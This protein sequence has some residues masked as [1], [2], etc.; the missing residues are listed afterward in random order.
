MSTPPTTITFATDPSTRVGTVTLSPPDERKPPT[1]DHATLAALDAAITEAEQAIAHGTVGCIFV[2]SASAKFFCAGANLSALRDINADTIDA[3]VEHGHR[4][5]ARLEDLSVPVVARVEGFALGGG[6]EL[7]LACDLIFA[8]A[9]ARVGQTEAQLGFVAGWGGS[10][11]LPRRVGESHAKELFFTGRIVSGGEAQTLGLVD[12]CGEAA[13]LEKHCSQFAAATVGNSA[14][15][16]AG[17]KQLLSAEARA[18]R[19]RAVEAEALA[20]RGCLQS[21]DTQLR[22]QAFFTRRTQQQP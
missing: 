12:F 11:R 10:W 5:F 9:A 14:T 19:T 7:A 2:R 22:L 15:S 17:H 8:S 4:V 3:W 13:A 21:P 1:F 18:A 6:L 16:H 20:S